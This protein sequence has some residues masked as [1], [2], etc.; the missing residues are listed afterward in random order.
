[1]KGFGT[2]E[3]ALINVLCKRT[4]EQ[5]LE[6]AEAFKKAYGK[7]LAEKIK[8]ETSGKF[9]TLMLALLTPLPDF[10]CRELKKPLSAKKI[11]V[12]VLCSLYNCEI[13]DVKECYSQTYGQD[14]EAAILG[15]GDSNTFQALMVALCAADRDEGGDVDIDAAKEDANNLIERDDVFEHEGIFYEMLRH[16]NVDQIR[17]VFREYQIMRGKSFLKLIKKTFGGDEKKGS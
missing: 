5:R 4:S 17:T 11:L 10:Y 9:E 16:R 13:E 14:L 12:E 15:D 6:I 1:M 7:T 2:D 8:S 3:D